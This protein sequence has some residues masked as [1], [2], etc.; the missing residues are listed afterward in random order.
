MISAHDVPLARVHLPGA[1]ER[2]R[3]MCKTCGCRTK[4]KATKKTAT[5]KKATKKKA[6]KKTKKK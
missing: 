4:K 3:V 2:R 5:K 1:E 6:V